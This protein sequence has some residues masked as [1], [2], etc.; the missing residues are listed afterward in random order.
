M[1]RSPAAHTHRVSSPSLTGYPP[2]SRNATLRSRSSF[3]PTFLRIYL[4]TL[5]DQQQ[6]KEVIVP[7]PGALQRAITTFNDLQDEAHQMVLVPE[8]FFQQQRCVAPPG[9]HASAAAPAASAKFE[10]QKYSMRGSEATCGRPAVAAGQKRSRPDSDEDCS[11]LLVGAVLLIREDTP[12]GAGRE[13][14][15]GLREQRRADGPETAELAV[16]ED[17]NGDV[18]VADGH[19]RPTSA[20]TH[21]A[22]RR[23]PLLLPCRATGTAGQPLHLLPS[24]SA[25]VAMASAGRQEHSTVASH[26][27]SILASA[28]EAA[29]S[30]MHAPAVEPASSRGIASGVGATASP[31]S[32]HVRNSDA[33]AFVRGAMPMGEDFMHAR[34]RHMR[35]VMAAVRMDQLPCTALTHPL[36]L[37]YFPAYPHACGCQSEL[38]LPC[39]ALCRQCRVAAI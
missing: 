26:R 29:W 17:S 1:H 36:L 22:M 30:H 11:D 24:A 31:T 25:A 16:Q 14:R 8:T 19:G 20:A 38:T 35:A 12:V 2:S 5:V 37:I 27:A 6:Q 28:A 33:A 4:R 23:L 39:F 9:R 32:G 10:R 18:R 7:Q 13:A 3:R 15:P 34:H 21:T